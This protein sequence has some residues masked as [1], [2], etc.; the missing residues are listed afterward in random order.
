MTNFLLYSSKDPLQWVFCLFYFNVLLEVTIESQKLVKS[1][2]EVLATLRQASPIAASYRLT[3]HSQN[4]ETGTGTIWS[5]DSKVHQFYTCVHSS[6]QFY[7]GY[8]FVS[9]QSGY[10][11]VPSL[12]TNCFVLPSFSSTHTTHSPPSWLTPGN[13]ESLLHLYNFVFFRMFYKQNHP[14]R[15]ALR[16]TFFT[17]H[18]ASEIH[19]SCCMHQYF[20]PLY[21]WGV[22]H[23]VD[24]PDCLTIHLLTAI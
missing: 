15:N 17:Q 22:F 20:T 13:H 8:R 18:N 14:V 1:S 4:R 19:L 11:T 6:K 24:A 16:R 3:V 12:Q 10:R 23:S 21:G 7:C 2:R 9:S 5:P